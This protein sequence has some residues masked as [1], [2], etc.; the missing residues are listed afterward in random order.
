MK[1]LSFWHCCLSLLLLSAFGACRV[2]EDAQDV[3]F[4]IPP[5]YTVDLFRERPGPA[6][7]PV[8][9][10]WLESMGNTECPDGI[11][12]QT[13]IDGSGIS[14]RILGAKKKASCPGDSARAKQFV[15]I[16]NLNDGI[17]TFKLSLRDV[18][19]NDGVLTVASGRYSLSMTAVQGVLIDNYVLEPAPADIVWGYVLTP[20]EASQPVSEN[21]LSDLKLQTGDKDLAPGFYG[22][23]TIS[24]TGKMILHKSTEPGILSKPFLRSLTKPVD[25]LRTLLQTYRAAAQPLQIRC[26][27]QEEEI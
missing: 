15:P 14:V 20:D 19:V 6:D 24:G 12:V 18:I 23:F 21:F 13:N 16:G 5:E 10:L 1:T 3:V 2:E 27:T 11:D 9:G 8:F 4:T 22:P 17:Y 25:D 7:A 26:W